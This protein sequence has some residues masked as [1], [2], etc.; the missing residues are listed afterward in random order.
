M[1]AVRR[2]PSSVVIQLIHSGRDACQTNRPRLDASPRVTCRS[3]RV[4]RRLDEDH[5]RD[6]EPVLTESGTPEARAAL[7]RRDQLT[8]AQTWQV[9]GTRATG[10]NDVTV[11]DAFVPL[12]LAPRFGAPA[13][14]VGRCTANPPPRW[15]GR[16]RRE[17]GRRGR[18]P[19]TGHGELRRL[20]ESL[21]PR[22]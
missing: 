20:A 15:S 3:P 11:E 12:E 22:F 4:R 1:V 2:R 13:E 6:G 16:D 18:K 21:A 19:H 10:R 17:S 14:I 7:L 9:N 8:V 5:K